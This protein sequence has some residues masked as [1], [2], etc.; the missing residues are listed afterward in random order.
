LKSSS[1]QSTRQ[2]LLSTPGKLRLL[3]LFPA[4]L[5]K[6][7][8]SDGK[9]AGAGRRMKGEKLNPWLGFVFYGF[10][11]LQGRIMADVAN[12]YPE[13]VAGEYYVDEQ[14]IDCDLCRENC[15]RQFQARRRSHRQCRR[16]EVVHSLNC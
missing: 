6:A 15:A 9:R 7:P 5:E 10:A 11:L 2:N 14:C 12:K 16:V 13:N 3:P 1:E 4:R 8:S